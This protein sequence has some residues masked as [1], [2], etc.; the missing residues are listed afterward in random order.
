MMNISA[1]G[2]DISVQI[3]SYFFLPERLSVLIC[4]CDLKMALRDISTT[5]NLIFL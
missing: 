3:N 1:S 4:V 2:S 5:R